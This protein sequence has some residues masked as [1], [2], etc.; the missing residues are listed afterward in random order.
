M[1]RDGDLVRGKLEPSRKPSF[2]SRG[3]KGAD[4]RVVA[5]THVTANEIGTDS[6]KRVSL[7]TMEDTSGRRERLLFTERRRKRPRLPGRARH[8]KAPAQDDW[9][10]QGCQR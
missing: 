3:R 7:L 6:R 5:K 1:G 2:E 9:E 8:A 4:G 10:R